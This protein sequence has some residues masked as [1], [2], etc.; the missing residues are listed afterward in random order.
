MKEKVREFKKNQII[1]EAIALIYEVG[2]HPAT[3]DRLCENLQVT[4]PFLYSYFDNK[5]ALLVEIYDRLMAMTAEGINKIMEQRALPEDKVFRI[6]EYLTRVNI[7]YQSICAIYVQEEKNLSSEKREEVQALQGRLDD[8]LTALIEQGVKDGV[9][10]VE[11]PRI[12][13]L[14]IYSMARWTL[15]W[16]RPG[17]LTSEQ[18]GQQLGQ[19]ALNL[20]QYKKR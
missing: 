10:E 19:Y 14:S 15:R 17:R 13:A 16:Y 12:A 6:A 18:I 8:H 7:D 2:F 20:L 9:F 4:K 3:M 1:E 5:H 11:H